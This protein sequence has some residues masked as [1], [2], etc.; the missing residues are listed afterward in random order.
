MVSADTYRGRR[1]S[2][3]SLAR[4]ILDGNCLDGK[5]FIS[6]PWYENK[7][8]FRAYMLP[9]I[10][11]EKSVLFL[12]FRNRKYHDRLDLVIDKSATC[13]DLLQSLFFRLIIL[14]SIFLEPVLADEYIF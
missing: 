2:L 11:N 10:G 4:D 14:V 6:R 12:V 3:K 13:P 9:L 7:S 5:Y 8:S 1:E